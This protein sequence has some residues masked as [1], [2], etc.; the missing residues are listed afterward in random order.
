M[1]E[2][3]NPIPFWFLRHGETDWNAE[4]LS[5]GRTDIALN[6][7]GIAQAE[8]AARTLQ[9]IGGIAT[10]VASPSSAPASRRRS[11]RRRLACRCP[12]TTNCRR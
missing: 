4:G 6:K 10:I 11:P 12:S 7:V 9:G 5:Q 8:R 1:A 2:T 3:L